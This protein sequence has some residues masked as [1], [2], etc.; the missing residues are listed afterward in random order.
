MDS[1]SRDKLLILTESK[2]LS[3]DLHTLLY[4]VKLAQTTTCALDSILNYSRFQ[5]LQEKPN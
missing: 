1:Q 2:L 5:I 3:P 4:A